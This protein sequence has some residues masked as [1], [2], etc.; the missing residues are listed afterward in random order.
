VSYAEMDR[1]VIDNATTGFC[2]LIAAQDTQMILGAHV[3]GEQALEVTQI[4]AAAMAANARVGDLAR[5]E[6]AYPTYS[7]IIGLAA[8]RI[9]RQMGFAETDAEWKELG[10]LQGAEWE[11]AD[12]VLGSSGS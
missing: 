11:R 6:I 9:V 10:R 7:G 1:A 2:K 12:Q 3:V 4:V 5:L 8:R